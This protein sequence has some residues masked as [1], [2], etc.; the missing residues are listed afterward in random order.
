[1]IG[2]N[3]DYKIGDADRRP[4]GSYVVTGVGKAGDGRD[5][6]EKEIIIAPGQILSLQSHKLRQE[7]WTLREGSLTVIRDSERRVLDPGQSIDI[8]VGAIHC[9]A[10]LGIVACVVTERQEGTCRE[11][12]IIRYSDVYNRDTVQ[13][14]AKVEESIVLYQQ[15][16]EDIDQLKKNIA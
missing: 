10:N 16:L 11:D 9:M 5:Y 7:F 12:D 4:W 14:D 6:C 2:Q 1:M 3:S 15:V 13:A 8:P